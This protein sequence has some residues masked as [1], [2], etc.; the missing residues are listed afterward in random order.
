MRRYGVCPKT[1]YSAAIAIFWLRLCS[2]LARTKYSYFATSRS[3]RTHSRGKIFAFFAFVIL[4][5]PLSQVYAGTLSSKTSSVLDPDTW[6]NAVKK[7]ITVPVST[8]SSIDVPSPEKALKDVSPKLKEINE[9]VREEIG[10]DFAKLIGWFAKVLG[11]V[12]QIVVNVLQAV[13]GALKQ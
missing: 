9:G 8:S 2:S 6:F 4:V 5:L 1:P 13:A 11:V 12:F 3:F 10:V 7:N